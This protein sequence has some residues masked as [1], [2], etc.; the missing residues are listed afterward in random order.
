MITFEEA[1]EQYLLKHGE[2][3]PKEGF[4]EITNITLQHTNGYTSESDTYYD[5]DTWVH[6]RET[7][8]GKDGRRVTKSRK[9]L[10][11]DVGENPHQL[12]Q[13]LFEIAADYAE[14]RQGVL[15]YAVLV[16]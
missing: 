8:H 6:Y 16:S 10:L 11:L 4:W 7:W 12:T 3:R 13:E 14:W 9:V 15:A 2:V 1:V 5:A